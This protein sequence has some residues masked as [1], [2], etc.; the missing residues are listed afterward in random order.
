MTY[1]ILILFLFYD[2]IRN[3]LF[4]VIKKVIAN[5]IKLIYI[6]LRIGEPN[7][8]KY[9][10]VQMIESYLIHDKIVF[11]IVSDIETDYRK[12]RYDID[13]IGYPINSRILILVIN[14]HWKA[15]DFKEGNDTLSI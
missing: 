5:K 10:S 12:I 11:Q 8:K 6:K 13:N 14:G 15:Y 7:E 1:F 4:N 9:K 3:E 2:I